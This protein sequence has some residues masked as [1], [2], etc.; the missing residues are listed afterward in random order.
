M[1]SPGTS[2]GDSV[3]GRAAALVAALF[4]VLA[5]AAPA[6]AQDNAGSPDS[7]AGVVPLMPNAEVRIDLEK[8]GVGNTA[9]RGDWCGIRL[10]L[11]DTG[12]KTRDVLIRLSMADPDGDVPEQQ[13]EITLNPGVPQGVWMYTRLPFRYTAGEGLTA[14]IHEALEGGTAPDGGPGF[15]AGKLLGRVALSPSTSSASSGVLP[16]ESG[17][18]A[19]LG[20]RPLGL[21]RYQERLTP[22]TPVQ[23]MGFEVWQVVNGVTPG[24][25]PDRWMGWAPFS[26][27]VWGQGEP[28]ELRGDRAK[29]LREW[30][31]RGGHLVIVLPQVGQTWTNAGSNDLHDIMPLVAVG[32]VENTDLLPYRPLFTQKAASAFPKAG[33]VHTFRPLPESN[34][35]DAIPILNGPDG[36][37]VVVRRLVG[38]GAVTLIGLDINATPFSQFDAMQTEVF[39]HRVLGRRGALEPSDPKAQRNIYGRGKWVVDADVG[40]LVSQT[41]RTFVGVLVGL[42]VFVIYWLVAGPVGYAVLKGKGFNKHAWVGFLLAGAAFTGVSWGG[43]R[44]LRP[45]KIDARHLTIIDHVYGQP[46][47]RARMWASVLI[48]SYGDSRIGVTPADGGPSAIVSAWDPPQDDAAWRAFPDARPYL[49]D[50]RNPSSMSLPTRATVKEVQVDWSGGPPWG[51]PIPVGE[52][53]GEGRL[54]LNPQGRT[55]GSLLEGTLT[56]KL[57][58]PLANVTIIVVEGQ[59]RLGNATP[60]GEVGGLPIARGSAFSL[61]G[62]WAPGT[63]LDLAEVTEALV[64]IPTGGG[65]GTAEEQRQGTNLATYLDKV[66]PQQVSN[67]FTPG[68][69]SD[70]SII[71]S[72]EDRMAA[73]AC[74][75]QLAPPTGDDNSS[76]DFS[77]LRVSTHNW[78]LSRWFTQPCVIIIGHL[79][80]A[81]GDVENAPSPVPLTV[82]GDPAPTHGRTVV[83]WVY[84]LP[85][86][87]PAYPGA[88]DPTEPA[89]PPGG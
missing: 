47:E 33:T 32:R 45:S 71:G 69:P 60:R 26:L 38:T 76:T 22:E 87:P 28:A 35:G 40:D 25:T 18:V 53:G 84:P 72:F 70:T 3:A 20:D 55:G 64:S 67:V 12:T 30:V 61:R 16:P 59:A 17:M 68:L 19:V 24:D 4:A 82:D 63:P 21:Q 77:A 81:A 80:S 41:G 46:T 83:R 44:V 75:G 65:A 5:F 78:D 36:K 79:E 88:N 29:A 50:T 57:P 2:R 56:H 11:T 66:R 85:A 1:Q 37:C 54:K 14:S 58:G 8:F 27:V 6:P 7:P 15:Q 10:R 89:T 62:S 49:I 13:R 23:T 39:W 51:M 52:N 31:G 73:L 43:A 34:A 9:R 42:V 48:P 74:M 86:D